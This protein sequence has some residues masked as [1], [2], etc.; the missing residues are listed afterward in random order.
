MRIR[1]VFSAPRAVVVPWNYQHYLMGAV[2]S[3]LINLSPAMNRY[4]HA[5]GISLGKKQYRMF[6]FSKLFSI[7][8]RAAPDGLELDAPIN[9]FVSSPLPWL[10][11]AFARSF[12]SETVVH[13]GTGQ[14]EACHAYV[15]PGLPEGEEFEFKT[16]SPLVTSEGVKRSDGR[17]WKAF[18]SP[19][20]P[21]FWTNLAE[22]VR[23]KA[24]ALQIDVKDNWLELEPRGHWRSRLIEVQGCKVKCYEGRFVARGNPV[25][26]R[27][28][29]DAGFGE[30]NSQ[31]FGMVELVDRP[32]RN[33][34]RPFR[35]RG[36]KRRPRPSRASSSSDVGASSQ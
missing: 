1:V 31:G 21:K 24:K 3:R 17:L 22:N 35:R 18:L 13:I 27:L 15:A 12:L 16:I 9:W 34:N 28:G 32:V 29:Y 2:Y 8:A 10:M 19:D 25:L 36:R 4:L 11:D 33:H 26:L 20:E 7:G 5:E 23:N 30:R 14:L 6:T